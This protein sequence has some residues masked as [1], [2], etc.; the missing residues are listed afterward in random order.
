VRRRIKENTMD[1]GRMRE[2]ATSGRPRREDWG[3]R[4]PRG[5]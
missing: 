2:R 5:A 4:G 3:G 1:L